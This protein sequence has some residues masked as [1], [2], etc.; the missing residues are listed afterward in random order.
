MAAKKTVK[1]QGAEKQT[2]KKVKLNKPVV[3]RSARAGEEKPAIRLG[4]LV[5]LTIFAAVVLTI[6]FLNRQDQTKTGD[7]LPTSA[8]PAF[9]FDEAKDGALTGI[10]VKPAETAAIKLTLSAG[11]WAFELPAPAAADQALVSSAATQ[12]FALKKGID[13]DGKMTI[14]GL[15]A[16]NYVIT[17]TFKG[18]KTHILEIGDATPTNSGYYARLDQGAAFITDLSGVDALSNLAEFPPY[19]ATPAPEVTPTP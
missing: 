14:F 5:T 16:P 12:V 9:L 7:A 8:A 1:K 18:G 2:P 15:D 19:A 3:R 6:I 17:L 4:T 10:E 11:Q 13:L